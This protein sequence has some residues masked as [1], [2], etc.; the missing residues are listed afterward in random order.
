MVVA[1]AAPGAARAGGPTPF[2]LGDEGE[3]VD[4]G[5]LARTTRVDDGDG[6]YGS[7]VVLVAGV[8]AHPWRALR[9]DVM[10]EAE[11]QAVSLGAAW[12]LSRALGEGRLWLEPWG[13]V[14]ASGEDGGLAE[15][16]TAS[17][18]RA[19]LSGGG[20]ARAGLDAT[21]R[22]GAFAITLGA[23]LH[24]LFA[25]DGTWAQ[26]EHVAFTLAL[27]RHLALVV[28]GE[29]SSLIDRDPPDSELG[30][31]AAWAARGGLRGRIGPA[32]LGVFVELRD[33]SGHP[34]WGLELTGRW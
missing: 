15:R 4:G 12:R 2:P 32:G 31:P 11:H 7:P 22:D 13:S 9:V 1:L 21:W 3:R 25:G 8:S 29:R 19:L 17:W 30:G 26:A 27:E 20:A 23:S 10:V 6:G 33:A 14:V 18:D 24:R 16:V 5:L 28:E 34:G